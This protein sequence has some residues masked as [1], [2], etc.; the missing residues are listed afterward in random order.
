MQADLA[1]AKKD[2]E[3]AIAVMQQ[4][5]EIYQARLGKDHPLTSHAMSRLAFFFSQTKHAAEAIRTMDRSLRALRIHTAQVL[6]I[7]PESEQLSFMA[8]SFAGDFHYAVSLGLDPKISEE[9]RLRTAGWV[10]N[11]KS[12]IH[13][14]LVERLLLARDNQSPAAKR[15]LAELEDVRG[16]LARLNLR[17][18]EKADDDAFGKELEALR[19][20]EKTL[21]GQLHNAGRTNRRDPWIEID[22]LRNKLPKNTV[23][24]DFLHFAPPNEAD[25]WSLKRSKLPPI[26]VAWISSRDD[27]TVIVNLGSAEK[28]DA[29]IRAARLELQQ[30]HG[31]IKQE[32]EIDADKLIQEKLAAVSKLVLA[33][34]LPHLSRYPQWILGPDGNLWLI[35]WACLPLD[36]KQAVLEKHTLRYV[37]SGRDLVLN[38]LQL[39]Q[40]S[41]RPVIF[42]DPD[43]DLDPKR[44][45]GADLPGQ[46]DL[47]TRT[48]RHLGKVSRLPGTAAEAD[49]IAPALEKSTGAFRAALLEGDA[50]VAAFQKLK[51]PKVLVMCTHGFFLPDQQVSQQLRNGLDDVDKPGTIP[52]LENP[53]LRSG[54]LLA[55]C[56][57]KSRTK[58]GFETGVLTGLEIVGTDLRGTE[59]VVFERLR[60]RPRR[61]PK[62]RRSCRTAT[63]VSPGRRPDRGRV[64]VEHPRSR[65]RPAHEDVF[66][67]NVRRQQQGGR[68]ARCPAHDAA[69]SAA[70]ATAPLIRST[71]PR[72]R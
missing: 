59:L 18:P 5:L 63:S 30:A 29:A 11:G 42:A 25:P 13:Q 50:T 7:L 21:E 46:R 9:N 58:D 72:S 53:L 66:R 70:N 56:N 20:K 24:V 44:A 3:Q 12:I 69:H 4:A 36:G 23:Y 48:L 54:L 15:I 8:A 52:G 61:G 45:G 60:H 43:F 49:A 64:L 26:Y 16:Q 62:R 51:G 28:I 40:R 34:L 1:W 17:G 71:G 67:E 65:D 33:P 37:T 35:P 38:P 47:G 22:E 32:G 6:P 2:P 27:E 68:H 39:D 14:S 19:G 55:G 57:H 41:T 10:L 31:R